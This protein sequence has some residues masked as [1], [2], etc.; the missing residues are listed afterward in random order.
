MEMTLII[1]IVIIT[2]YKVHTNILLTNSNL[3]PITTYGY[4]VLLKNILTRE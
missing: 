3:L 4:T 1:V 2:I